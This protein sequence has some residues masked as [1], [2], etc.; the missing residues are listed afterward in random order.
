MTWL[1]RQLERFMLAG[2]VLLLFGGALVV[3]TFVQVPPDNR[4]VII[5]LVGGINALTGMVIGYYFGR[6]GAQEGTSE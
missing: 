6:R 1:T 3:M 2:M 5:Q 4:D